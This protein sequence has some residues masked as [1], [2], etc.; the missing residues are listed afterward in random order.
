MTI[1]DGSI[2]SYRDHF[3]SPDFNVVGGHFARWMRAN[4]PDDAE[5]V[6]FGSWNSVEEAR[7]NGTVRAH[8]AGEWGDHLRANGCEYDDC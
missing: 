5:V 6:S 3:G 8:Y 2:A 1:N 7:L 4:H